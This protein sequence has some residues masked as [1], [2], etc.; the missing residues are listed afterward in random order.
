M[1]NRNTS[2]PPLLWEFLFTMMIAKYKNDN[3]NDKF[4][5]NNYYRIKLD[6]NESNQVTVNKKAHEQSKSTH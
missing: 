4:S 2:T 3:K 6:D 1:L 5:K